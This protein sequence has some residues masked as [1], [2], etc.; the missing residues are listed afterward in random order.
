MAQQYPSAKELREAFDKS[1][2]WFF[3]TL[4]HFV[5]TMTNM[6][7]YATSRTLIELL[8][9]DPE[10]KQKFMDRFKQNLVEAAKLYGIKLEQVK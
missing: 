8:E 3:H 7:L 6:M 10:L 5:G 1:Y 2:K 9:E 4:R